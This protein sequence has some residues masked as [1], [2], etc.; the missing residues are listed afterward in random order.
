MCIYINTTKKLRRLRRLNATAR[1]Q[2][3][4]T[5][6]TYAVNNIINMKRLITLSVGL[7]LTVIAL[8]QDTTTVDGP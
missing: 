3:R 4:S 8:A 5:F 2:L 1:Q 7:F 6:S